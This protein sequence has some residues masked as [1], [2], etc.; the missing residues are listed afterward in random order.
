MTPNPRAPL[1]F[2][3]LAAAALVCF[4]A[5]NCYFGAVD[6]PTSRKDVF[7]LINISF[8]I[9]TTHSH[10]NSVSMEELPR[11][12]TNQIRASHKVPKNLLR[13]TGIIPTKRALVIASLLAIT[14]DSIG[15]VY[16]IIRFHS[17]KKLLVTALGKQKAAYENSVGIMARFVALESCHWEAQPSGEVHRFSISNHPG[18]INLRMTI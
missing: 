5:W 9:Q 18:S 16:F 7:P 17:P 8:C 3:A 15:Y 14:I 13:G 6:C 4:G 1:W 2:L 12:A 11:P 10:P